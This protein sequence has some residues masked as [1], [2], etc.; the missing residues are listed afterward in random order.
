MFEYYAMGK[1]SEKIHD[2]H[3]Y[4]LNI[5]NKK[6]VDKLAKRKTI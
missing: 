2:I 6:M 3:K 4:L 5:C 1:E